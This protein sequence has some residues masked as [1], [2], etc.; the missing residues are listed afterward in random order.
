MSDARRPVRRVH[1]TGG[2]GSGKTTLARRIGACLGVPVHD[3]DLVGWDA[4]TGAERPLDVRLA[5]VHQLAAQPG[6]VTEG[7]MLGWADPL[8]RAADLIVWLDVPWRV[9]VWRMVQRHV[10]ASLAGNNRH[11]GV[12]KLARF[13]W[14]TCER[15]R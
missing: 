10:R 15:G 1:I 2:Q 5:E 14:Y 12:R 7:T 3:L 4:Q 9:A 8:F 11:P 6:W 13:I